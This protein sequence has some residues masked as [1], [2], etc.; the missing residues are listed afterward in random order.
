[1]LFR[2]WTASVR[3]SNKRLRELLVEA[4]EHAAAQA[5]GTRVVMGGAEQK[6]VGRDAETIGGEAADFA[7]DPGMHPEEVAGDDRGARAGAVVE[8]EGARKQRVVDPARGFGA[9]AV[10]VHAGRA[11]RGDVGN[12]GGGAETVRGQS[13]H[14]VMVARSK[15]E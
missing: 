13:T 3:R 2:S 4:G 6:A 10:A 1:M 9:G 8:D 11:L 5:N 12:R 14:A 15:R 7:R